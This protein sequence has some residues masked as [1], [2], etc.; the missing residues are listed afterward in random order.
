[1]A[2]AGGKFAQQANCSGRG[3]APA[4]NLLTLS[5]MWVF[6]AGYGGWLFGCQN[7]T[8]GCMSTDNKKNRSTTHHRG[9]EADK[10][11]R[12]FILSDEDAEAGAPA[13]SSVA[14][15]EDPGVGLE[16]LVKRERKKDEGRD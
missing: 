16:F 7:K 14:G 12:D 6:Q 13:D 1:M 2:V 8:G 3:F 5:L 11:S 10:P 9:D 15:E 4:G